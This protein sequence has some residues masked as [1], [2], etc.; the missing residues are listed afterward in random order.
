MFKVLGAFYLR[1]NHRSRVRRLTL[2][3]IEQATQKRQILS[4]R[5][6]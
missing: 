3:R 2:G 5:E 4:T 6:D 1:K